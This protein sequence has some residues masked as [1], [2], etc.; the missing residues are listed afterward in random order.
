M[1]RKWIWQFAELLLFAGSLSLALP[2]V[3]SNAG[4]T[5]GMFPLGVISVALFAAG[6]LASGIRNR[7]ARWLYLIESVV[8]AAFVVAVRLRVQIN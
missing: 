1:Y 4:Q 8:F 5:Y 6:K 7:E 3:A 2:P